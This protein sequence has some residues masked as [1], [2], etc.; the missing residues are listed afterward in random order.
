MDVWTCC[1]CRGTISTA[2]AP[3]RCPRCKHTRCIS[4]TVS[5][6]DPAADSSTSK[7][8]GAMP[9]TYRTEQAQGLPETYLAVRM[10][11]A[12]VPTIPYPAFPSSS[13]PNQSL[14]PSTA[15]QYPNANPVSLFEPRTLPRGRGDRSTMA[16]PPM[17]GWWY[18]CCDHSLN[19]PAL[20]AG[21]CT[22][23]GH[24]KCDGCRPA[25]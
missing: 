13:S 23:C 5:S 2:I 3:E 10:Y 24:V 6:S 7:A 16:V 25:A 15:P 14:P 20:C 21:R 11:E 12:P 18:C 17:A 8:G 9:S 4:C 1:Q 22:T 19:N